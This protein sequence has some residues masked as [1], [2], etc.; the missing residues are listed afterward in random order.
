MKV[1]KLDKST[2]RM[3]VSQYLREV[4]SYSGRSLRNIKVYLDGKL[5]KSSK[6]LPSR[7]TI[8]IEEKEKGTNIKPIFM[9]LDI[10]Y[11]DDELLV[12]NKA[13]N[14]IVHPTLKKA[15]ITLANGIV[16]YLNKV[17]R[18]FNRLDMDT[19][20]L[21]IIA[22][23]AFAQSYLQ[24]FGE[25]T[26]K[27][28]AIVEG[29]LDKEQIVEAK[30]Y[31]D[32]DKLARIVDDRGQEAKTK[33]IPLE[34]NED[35]DVSLVECELYTGRTHQIR[36]HLKHIG[37]SLVGDK[38]YNENLKYKVRQLLHSYKLSFRHPT[39]KERVDIEIP[40]YD[41]MKVFMSKD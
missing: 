24:N 32:G 36:V 34:Y 31:R 2:H 1:Y 4:L 22:K 3:K 5:V 20:G 16:A 29:K 38:L 33:F 23:T 12:I 13:P 8:R 35:K 17:P 28:L 6:K 10:V 14:L 39:T 40:M 19:S 9:D 15:D 37:H 18:F 41:D 25:L 11:E 21:I 30:I 27:Y 7:G 26:K